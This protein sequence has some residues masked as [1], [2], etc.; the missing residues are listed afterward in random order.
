MYLYCIKERRRLE[1]SV[2]PSP[3]SGDEDD[4]APD[5]LRLGQ[6]L[7]LLKERPQIA[8]PYTGPDG[9]SPS[10]TDEEDQAPDPPATVTHWQ[11]HYPCQT[12]TRGT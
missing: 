11:R 7:A 1:Q 12:A 8:Q 6:E 3:S 9:A 4:S 10:V 2:P 5:A